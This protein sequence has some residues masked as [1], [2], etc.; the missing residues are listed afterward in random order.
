MPNQN[1]LSG[2]RQLKTTEVKELREQLLT[3]QRGICPLCGKAITEPCLDHQHK[4]RKIDIPGYDGA[5]LV[6]G[7]LC[8]DCNSLEGRIWNAMTRHIQPETVS[9]RVTWLKNLINYYN[10]EPQKII[11]P[12]E[13][14]T[15]K[16]S[17]RNFNIL[18]KLYS[19][20]HP[21][22]KM[23]EFPKSGLCTKRLQELFD[24]YKI[25]PWN[26]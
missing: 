20:D 7:V 26:P 14:P 12:G 24:Y 18:K 10:K 4:R 1:N 25:S 19:Q 6:R 16:L 21:R 13:T 22:A 2:L 17:K 11:Y 23:L 9:D 8:R 3:E 5:G 15:K